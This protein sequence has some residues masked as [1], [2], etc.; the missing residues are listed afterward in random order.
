MKEDMKDLLAVTILI[1]FAMLLLLFVLFVAGK[2]LLVI[3]LI[4]GS[5]GLL[6]WALI[7]LSGLNK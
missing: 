1:F 3:I 6:S 7:R 4:L 2:F 5:I